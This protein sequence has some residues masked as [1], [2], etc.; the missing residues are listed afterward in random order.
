[1]ILR[2][3]VW[4]VLLLIP[5]LRVSGQEQEDSVRGGDLREVSV[6]AMKGSRY[7]GSIQ[8]REVIGKGDLIRAACCNLGESFTNSAS[9]DVS[10]A[11]PTTGVRQVKLLGLSGTYVQMMTENIPT[12]RGLSQPYALTFVPG[13]W[14]SSIQV[15]KGAS[16][17]KNGYESM[18]GQINIEYLKPQS[19]DA[20]HVN[21][22]LNNKLA[23]EWNVDGNKHLG[24][25][26][27]WSG[28]FLL[29]GDRNIIQRDMNG[30]GFR[31]EP[32]GHQWNAMLRLAYVSPRYIMQ[33][34]GSAIL[35]SKTGG[36]KEKRYWQ[37]AS[38]GPMGWQHEAGKY[39]I[40][41]DNHRLDLHLKN[42]YIF[43]PEKDG[44]VA[45]ILSGE[46]QRLD[47][48][49][50]MS[51]DY[52]VLQNNMYA[53]LL[54]EEQFT[55]SHG[56]S[57][58]LSLQRDNFT[59]EHVFTGG[60]YSAME[61]VQDM[62]PRE[63]VAGAYAQYTYTLDDKLTLMAGL[64]ADRSSLYGA[65]VT[66]RAHLRWHPA[67]WFTIRA[68]VGKG[69]RTPHL[70]PEM[71]HLMASNRQWWVQSGNL[72]QEESWNTGTSMRFD[73]P[74]FGRTLELN[75]DYYYTRFQQQLV[76]DR[77]ADAH[78]ILFYALPEGGKSFSH[79][80]QLDATYPFFEGFELT[81]A[82]RL[83]HVRTTY[84]DGRLRELPLT[85]RWKG[86]V[87]ATYKTPLEL[88]QFD[89]TC[90][91]NGPGR[92]P[93]PCRIKHLCKSAWEPE[94]KAFP[95][96]SAQVT[97]FFRWGS[98]YAGGENLTNFHL[99]HPIIS[100]DNPMSPDFDSNMIWG[101]VHGAMGYVGVRF[102][103]E[104]Y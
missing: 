79:C 89:V 41:T 42:A 45:L 98:I 63:T 59:G 74:L 90:Q 33:M 91:V 19:T 39:V 24:K 46:R 87:T 8:S 72:P 50:T 77:D 85:N 86:L 62:T 65:F 44:N 17:V 10:Y 82:W 31:D 57:A 51:P 6:G 54:F 99:M 12:F 56:L 9:V 104:K 48:T 36:Q 20:L 43:N 7:D 22:Y 71:H 73:I 29:H 100:A 27:R 11:D 60:S 34:R 23:Y 66:P 103:L 13:P 70:Y 30:D 80:L 1:M 69:Y 5:A 93:D 55:P 16:S 64:R 49:G 61:Q 68:S 26:G 88:W 52:E 92:M 15:S 78:S 94:Y 81:A 2:Q 76:V 21:A 96:L 75:A 97:R 102:N 35:D 18:T 37:D 58:G 47:M 28:G 25:S 67:E 101:P 95:Q 3:T 4:L 32:T 38:E 14:L 53:S 83:N 40:D 84:L